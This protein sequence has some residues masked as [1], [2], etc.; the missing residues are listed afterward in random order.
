VAAIVAE[1]R[2]SLL[3]T[4][5][6]YFFAKFPDKKA[7][8]AS[9]RTLCGPYAA[10][11]E[12]HCPWRGRSS[13]ARTRRAESLATLEARPDWSQAAILHAQVLRK[14]APA[15][16]IPFYESFVARHP[17]SKDVWLQLAREYT[18][19]KRTAEARTAF[20]T[21]EKLAPAD[22]QLPYAVG[23]LALQAG[24]FIE[25]DEALRRSL[26]TR[27]RRGLPA[28]GRSPRAEEAEDA[29]DW[30]RKVEGR[31]M[32]PASHRHARRQARQPR[33]G[34]IPAVDRAAHRDD[35]I[36][37]SDRGAA[38]ARRAR[39]GDT[40]RCSQAVAPESF[41]LRYD[42]AMAAERVNKLDVLADLRRVIEM[43][44]DYAHA[45]NALGYTLADRTERID[46]AY[47]L[48][49]KARTL[50]PDDPFILDSLGW[51]Q[52]RRGQLDEALKHLR[53]AYEARPD[54]EIAAHGQNPPEARRARRGE[55]HLAGRS[56]EPEPRDASRVMQKFK[57]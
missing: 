13:R 8:L 50:S 5:L 7:V 23:L 15:Q 16:V 17:Q 43:K 9:V 38:P 32:R 14:L 24:D 47:A 27:I 1:R 48:I 10:L 46:E 33:E 11:P 35:R 34:R 2:P 55:P 30:Y 56:R 26:G 22:P 12:T 40:C 6:S 57:P 45:Y 4:Q 31:L 37:W 28:S 49:E 19:A 29:I 21:A 53:S 18:T 52:Y 41:E 36:R 25:A 3:I 42:R 39:W 44:P 20:R 54:P 51:V